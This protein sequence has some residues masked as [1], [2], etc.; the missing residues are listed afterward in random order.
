MKNT[1][2][3]DSWALLS[4]FEGQEKGRKVTKILETAADGK[5]RLFLSVVNWGEI[6]YVIHSRYGE[7]KRSEIEHLMNQMDITVVNIDRDIVRQA[8]AFKAVNKLPYADCFAAA[9]AFLERADIVTG[10][11]DFSAVEDKV[12]IEWL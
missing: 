9:L 11:K 5:C 8:A 2:V 7:K 6:L 1:K 4:Y 3:L 10:D 12:K